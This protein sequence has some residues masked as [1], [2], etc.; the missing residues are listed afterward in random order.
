MLPV[1][2]RLRQRAVFFSVGFIR[3]AIC[4]YSMPSAGPRHPLEGPLN[5][6][7]REINE[8]GLDLP[9]GE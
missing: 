4:L 7:I 1:R 9:K 8:S 5:L 6:E 2:K 3:L